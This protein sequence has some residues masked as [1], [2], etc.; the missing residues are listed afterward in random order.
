MEQ[1]L[2]VTSERVDDIPLLLAQQDR[3]EVSTLL[4]K[5]FIPNGNWKGLSLGKVTSVWLSHILSEGDH[6]LNHVEPWA[7]HRLETLSRCISEPVRGL[8]FSDDRLA[9]ILGELSDD[10][11]WDNFEGELAPHLLRVY[12][13]FPQEGVEAPFDKLKTP[14]FRLDSTASSGYWKVTEEGLFQFGHSKDHRPDLPQVKVML[15]TLD[16]LGL[17]IGCEVISGEQADDGLYIPAVRK[18]RQTFPDKKGLFFIGD[19]KLASTENR[20]FIA[21]GEDFYLCPLPK[22]QLSDEQLDAYLGPVWEG[23]QPLQSVEYQYADGRQE[24]IAEGYEVLHA[25]SAEINGQPHHW[26]ERR[27]VVRS[28]KFA[29]SGQRKLDERLQE[30]TKQLLSSNERKQGKKRYTSQAELQPVVEQIL[31]EKGLQELLE[32]TYKEKIF[33]REIR[34]YKDRPSRIEE[35]REVIVEVEINEAAYQKR[36]KRLG[37]RVYACNVP[38]GLLP[39][40]KAILAYRHEF[41]VERSFARLKGKPLSLRPM[42]L[43]SEA[44]IVGL[45]RLLSI[46]LRVLVLVEYQLRQK[47][48]EEE[49]TLAGLYAGNPKRK[50]AQPTT[51][52]VLKAFRYITL[53]II[54]QHNQT[55]YHLTELNRLQTT[56]LELLNFSVNIYTQLTSQSDKPG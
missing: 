37:W 30:T 1:Q 24:V 50:T 4:D 16:P 33:Q 26:Q 56:I 12:D 52:Q 21:F 15:S 43:Q 22:S 54:H 10:S 20:G 40:E 32:I 49:R 41:I 19:S 27:L 48:A 45:I 28:F 44:H 36:V 5:H 2:Q 39:L 9:L 46:A 31:E 25:M 38:A 3:M 42:Y 13:L 23:K 34:G 51:E 29:E 55:L 8:D 7:S 6:R 17:P 47:L 18:V 35:N 14:P 11:R 53:T